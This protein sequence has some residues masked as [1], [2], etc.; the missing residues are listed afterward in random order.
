MR[1]SHVGWNLGGLIA[2]LAIAV[3]TVPQLI[4]VLGK[5]RFGLLALAWGLVGYASA[6]DL[7]IGRALTQMVAKMKGDGNLSGISS[8]LFTASRITIVSGSIAGLIIFFF[9]LMGGA[10]LINAE[11]D[12]EKEIKF[13]IFILAIALPVQAMS[14]TYRGVNEAFL[15]FRSISILRASLGIINFAGPYIISLYSIKLHYLIA[16]IIV[17]R[18]VAFI[19]Y[20]ILAE[21]CI[22]Q[23]INADVNGK[24]SNTIAR[25]L[26]SFGSWVTVSS[27]VSPMLV[28]ADRF[29]IA[30]IISAAAVS[31]YVIPYEAVVQSLVLVGAISSVIFP[32]LSAMLRS[33]PGAARA[34]FNRWLLRVV[35]IMS[36]V[37]CSM[38]LL[39]P[40]IL[41]LWIKDLDVISIRVGQIL[42]AG[43]FANSMGVMFYALIHAQGKSKIT[44]KIH[45][46]ELPIFALSLYFLVDHLGVLGAA[47]AWVGRMS[48]DALAL[49]SQCYKFLWKD[50]FNEY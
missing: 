45:L 32:S 12:L 30:T 16:S 5:E 31:T 24:Y 39:L 17:S 15:K 7:G 49:L 26:F 4:D 19:F 22:A 38:A 34:F 9:G 36:M 33:D 8:A 10:G 35:G 41:P 44:A 29:F 23:E 42:C 47:I 11:A 2:P 14:A 43:V 27:V 46:L 25:Q 13:S 1:L 18:V 6:M 37:C 3:L 40:Y 48:F 20:K 50:H 21:R 28:Q